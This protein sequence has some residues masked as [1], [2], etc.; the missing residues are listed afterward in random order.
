MSLYKCSSVLLCFFLSVFA[1]FFS[2]FLVL[3]FGLQHV[4]EDVL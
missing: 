1:L 2:F 4:A 3:G